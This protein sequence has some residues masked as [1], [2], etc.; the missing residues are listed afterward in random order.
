MLRAGDGAVGKT[1]LLI[2]Y[3]SNQFPSSYTPT[4]F[5]NY[6]AN[7]IVDGVPVN[8]NIWD[9]GGVSCEAMFFWFLAPLPVCA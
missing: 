4:V 2:S 7:V 3:T 8:L 9:T 6:T 5:D 1:A